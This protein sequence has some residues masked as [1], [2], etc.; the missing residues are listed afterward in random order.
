[1]MIH[2]NAPKKS[3]IYECPDCVEKF[4]SIS[5]VRSHMKIHH[6][7]GPTLMCELCGDTFST[8]LKL[9]NHMKIH[10]NKLANKNCESNLGIHKKEK[11]KCHA[12]PAKF[13]FFK[14]FER[15]I[16]KHHIARWYYQCIVCSTKFKSQQKVIKHYEIHPEEI[17]NKEDAYGEIFRK[18]S[19]FHCSTCDKYF[20]NKLA[21]NTH[22]HNNKTV[23]SGHVEKSEKSNK[24]SNIDIGERTFECEFCSKLFA[25]KN[26]LTKHKNQVHL[27]V[28]IYTCDVCDKEFNTSSKLTIH[29]RIHTGERPF[30]CDVC[31][32]TFIQTS[33]L[34]RHRR[35]TLHH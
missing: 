29:H 17:C 20:L 2:V 3:H 27:N 22:S 9:R 30:K 23:T 5:N 14:N 32:R 7:M 4:D 31:P 35:L 13:K 26:S 21:F 28:K 11:H 25:K 16:K 6:N 10:A 15:H 8:I 1:M 33:D 34:T 24:D 12:C 18:I 19:D